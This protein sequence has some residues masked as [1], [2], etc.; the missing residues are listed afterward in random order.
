MCTQ[1]SQ[2]VIWDIINTLFLTLSLLN[3]L[4]LL[5]FSTHKHTSMAS[6]VILSN[7]FEKQWI[8]NHPQYLSG[9]LR[10]LFPTTFLEIAVYRL[11]IPLYGSV[12]IIIITTIILWLPQWMGHSWSWFLPKHHNSPLLNSSPWYQVLN[13]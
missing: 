5:S 12:Q 7:F 13:H 11:S 1:Q 3:L 4:L 9:L 8:Q 10:A 6:R 2:N